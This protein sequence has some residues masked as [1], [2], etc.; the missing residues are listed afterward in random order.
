MQHFASPLSKTCILDPARR[1]REAGQD[2]W[3]SRLARRRAAEFDKV[4]KLNTFAK[5]K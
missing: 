1:I 3:G 5:L 4:L 2:L